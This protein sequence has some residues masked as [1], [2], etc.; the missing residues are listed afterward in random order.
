MHLMILNEVDEYMQY[1]GRHLVLY[2]ACDKFTIATLCACC[3]K[4]KEVIEVIDVCKL[5]ST[6]LT[7][8]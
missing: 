5:T 7:R 3:T 8:N 4:I 2:D 6:P 1:D